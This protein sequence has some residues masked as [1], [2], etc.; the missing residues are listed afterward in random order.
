MIIIDATTIYAEEYKLP[1]Q[2]IVHS[3]IV[4]KYGFTAG[5]GMADLYLKIRNRLGY[6]R[7]RNGVPRNSSVLTDLEILNAIIDIIIE[8][9]Q[10]TFEVILESAID[11]EIIKIMA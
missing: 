9:R 2:F 11:G 10:E 6:Y 7:G 4:G 8:R 5:D 1:T 3:A